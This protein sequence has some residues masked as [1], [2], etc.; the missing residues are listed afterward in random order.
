MKQSKFIKYAF[1]EN[2]DVE[3]IDTDASPQGKVSIVEGYTQA[4]EKDAQAGGE[5][6]RRRN[7]N[8]ILNYFT[9]EILALQLNGVNEVNSAILTGGGYP[10]GGRCI[11]WQ[12]VQTGA[13]D[14]NGSTNP[15]CKSVEVVSMKDNN[16]TDPYLERALFGDW[17][18]DDGGMI[19]EI[20]VVQVNLSAPPA[21]YLDLAP[22]S[23]NPDY[24]KSQYPRI[25]AILGDS[26]NSTWGFFQST[27]ATNFTIINPR[28]RFARVWSNGSTI[29]NGRA[30]TD[31]QG[32][33]IRNITNRKSSGKSKGLYG[34]APYDNMKRALDGKLPGKDG[35]TFF[36]AP[37]HL[38][39]EDPQMHFAVTSGQ[40]TAYTYNVDF[41]ASLAVPTTDP[42]NGENRP[43]NFNQKMYI[44]V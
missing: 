42:Q 16:N 17:F 19:G 26:T 22:D 2:G 30:F 8:Y 31:L 41:D 39:S 35:Y 29:D 9:K 18:L 38:Q 12:N 23:A 43:Y 7:F 28:G 25:Q 15:L 20:K 1:A 36:Q 34:A 4:Y 14:R 32:D 33:A 10:K 24:V 21:G 13:L 27:S 5:Y 3:S 40:I 6:I 37:F 44:K 11:V